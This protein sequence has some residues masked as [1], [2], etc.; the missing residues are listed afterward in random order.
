MKKFVFCTVIILA[1]SVV[2]VL[3]G[4]EPFARVQHVTLDVP[5]LVSAPDEAI[6]RS[7]TWEYGG[8]DWDWEAQISQ[9]HYQTLR[10]KPRPRIG[11]HA[12]YSVYVT[13]SLDDG[14]FQ[15]LAAVIS[16]GRRKPRLY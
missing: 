3:L 2:S 5:S 6:M 7:F 14:F 9:Q 4:C 1:L 12:N 10:S 8:I 16:A 13:Q 15:N 11:E